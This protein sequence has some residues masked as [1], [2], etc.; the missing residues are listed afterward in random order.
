MIFVSIPTVE[1]HEPMVAIDNELRRVCVESLA[2]DP[3]DIGEFDTIPTVELP[4]P[5]VAIE[6]RTVCVESFPRVPYYI[7][8]L[9]KDETLEPIVY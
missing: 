7:A 4:E 2:W 5:M 8:E 6:L 3:N 9:K 1:L